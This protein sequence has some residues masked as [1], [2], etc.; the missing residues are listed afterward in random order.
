MFP[1][2]GVDK[3]YKLIVAISKLNKGS[4]QISLNRNAENPDQV[5]VYKSNFPMRKA[6]IL[7]TSGTEDNAGSN[8]GKHF[9]DVT[10]EL[11]F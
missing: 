2:P 1:Y 8:A 6:L 7:D 11:S 5:I 3:Y 10:K 9:L 4:K